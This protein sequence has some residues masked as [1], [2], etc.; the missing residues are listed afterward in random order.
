MAN[1]RELTMSKAISEAIAQE[2]AR[3]PKVFVMG[4]DVGIYGGAAQPGHRH[5]H[6]RRA[7]RRV[8]AA[9]DHGDCRLLVLQPS[10]QEDAGE[11]RDA[12]PDAPAQGELLTAAI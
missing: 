4:E 9:A 10:L 6:H 7:A 5:G 3:D 8:R 2:M 11:G 1:E 12:L